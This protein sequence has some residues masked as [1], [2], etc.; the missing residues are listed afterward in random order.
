MNR[1][2]TGSGEF[3]DNNGAAWEIGVYASQQDGKTRHET[4]IRSPS[5]EEFRPEDD[6]LGSM[7]LVDKEGRQHGDA[8]PLD[9]E[10]LQV[11]V[12][13]VEDK[14]WGRNAPTNNWRERVEAQKAA[15]ST[16]MGGG[17]T[18]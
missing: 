5:G 14:A 13:H 3:R 7:Y 11:A 17:F 18:R 15:H 10:A 12:E 1:K 9:M 6:V 8:L 2:Q 4:I 16:E